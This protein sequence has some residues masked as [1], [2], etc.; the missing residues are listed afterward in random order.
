VGYPD[1]FSYNDATRTLHVG[2]GEFAPVSYDV[3]NFEVSGLKVV[4]SWLKYRMKRGAGRKSSPLDDLRPERWTAELTS[5][6]LKLLWILEATLE[7][8]PEQD[9]LLEDILSGP[10]FLAEELPETPEAARHAPVSTV[11]RSEQLQL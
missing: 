10:L 2:T 4:Q 5:E 7:G 6:L 8:D 9:Q 1:N 3:F 11:A